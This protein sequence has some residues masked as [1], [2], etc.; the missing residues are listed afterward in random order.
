M[1]AFGFLLVLGMLW[2]MAWQFKMLKKY[3]LTFDRFSLH[4]KEGFIQINEQVIPL[5]E[6]A[7]ARVREKEQP[8]ATE[9]MLSKSAYYAFMAEIVFHLQDDTCV[10]C[11]FNTKGA[12]YKALKQLTPYVQIN[13]NIDVYKPHFAWGVLLFF[14]AGLIAFVLFRACSSY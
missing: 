11:A 9:K 6:I 7:F 13:G 12:L 8:T 14:A 1:Y 2:F 10:C 5:G 4:A 3:V